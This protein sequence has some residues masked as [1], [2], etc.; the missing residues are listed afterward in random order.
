MLSGK[1]TFRCF[2]NDTKL[3]GEDQAVRGLILLEGVLDLEP[4]TGGHFGGALGL[5]S[6]EALIVTGTLDAAASPA[7]IAF[8]MEGV[9]GT[10]TD[11]RRYDG[12]G[13]FCRAVAG[14][15][16]LVGTLRPGGRGEVE[17]SGFVAVRHPL[18]PPPR[19]ARRSILAAGL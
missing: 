12:E 9:S 4:G 10:R 5:S 15:D 19:T 16:L 14:P 1:W 13:A 2:R 7:R 3:A 17:R 18:R 8:Q 11:G 6:G